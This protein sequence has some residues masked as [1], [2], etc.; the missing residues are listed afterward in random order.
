MSGSGAG[1][2]FG[3]VKFPTRQVQASHG[4]GWCVAA[5]DT[6]LQPFSNGLCQKKKRTPEKKIGQQSCAQMNPAISIPKSR[7]HS[8][9]PRG[10]RRQRWLVRVGRL[11]DGMGGG[12]WDVICVGFAILIYG[13]GARQECRG[14]L[15]AETDM[16]TASQALVAGS[17]HLGWLQLNFS[18]D[19]GRGFEGAK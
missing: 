6:G 18:G 13:S 11:G 8:T 3:L 14:R 17:I 5:C 1:L 9:V 15:S 2:G 16:H 19:V 10:Y 7:S 4:G 12:D